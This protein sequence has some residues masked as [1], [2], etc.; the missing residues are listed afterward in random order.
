MSL[1]DLSAKFEVVK[2][3]MM[4]E[5]TLAINEEFKKVFELYPEL[6]VVKWKQYTPYFNDGEECTFSVGDFCISNAA[7]PELVTS[8]G[9]YEGDENDGTF[10]FEGSW[11]GDAKKYAAVWELSK[12]SSTDIGEEVFRSAF[13]NHVQVTVTNAGIDVSEYEHD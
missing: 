10:V 13:G 5:A 2:K 3:Q 8:Y 4:D 9:E 11:D 12:F 6:T 1:A 7:D